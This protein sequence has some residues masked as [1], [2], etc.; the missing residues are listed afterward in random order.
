METFNNTTKVVKDDLEKKISK[1]NAGLTEYLL[2]NLTAAKLLKTAGIRK[3]I[4]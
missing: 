1:L 3:Y 2:N 4:W